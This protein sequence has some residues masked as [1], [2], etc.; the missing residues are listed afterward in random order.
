MK[1]ELTA[2]HN[3]RDLARNVINSNHIINNTNR[4]MKPGLLFRSDKLSKLT[5]DDVQKIKEL[6]IKHIIDFRSASEK[7]H[8]PN[9]LIEGMNYIEMPIDADSNFDELHSILNGTSDKNVK[10]FL[11]DVNH[12][13]IVKYYHIFS[14]FIKIILEKREPILFHCTAGKDR[15]GFA[16]A[17]ILYLLD[18]NMN[19]IYND[20]LHSNTCLEG[21]VSGLLTYIANLMNVSEE[22]AQLLMPLLIVDKEYLDEAFI[23]ANAVHGSF[24]NYIAD[25]L[26]ITP[27]MIG[28]LRN[29]LLD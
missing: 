18:F 24:D 4:I 27:D 25:K 15:T 16:A 7:N 10:N 11:I 9:T 29:Y 6:N 3:T 26:N 2:T 28:E 12:D 17:L 23:T 5:N 13:F 21:N 8:S 20:Y 1:I 22:R 14:D 19:Y